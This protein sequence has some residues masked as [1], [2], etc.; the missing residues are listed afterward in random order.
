MRG[1]LQ[2][3]GTF[4]NQKHYFTIK[5]GESM[6]FDDLPADNYMVVEDT[7]S[8]AVTGYTFNMADSEYSVLGKVTKNGNANVELVN[9][10]TQD[11]GTLRVTKTAT[12]NNNTS[13]SGTF[14]FSVKNFYNGFRRKSLCNNFSLFIQHVNYWSAVNI[15]ECSEIRV[16]IWVEHVDE[17]EHVFFGYE[18]LPFVHIG[19]SANQK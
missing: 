1:Y 17:I 13:V 15:I 18:F 8:V 9:K 5:A 7:D 16:L 11:L 19:L 14:E 2:D 3:D 4:G 12:D 6:T 10:Y